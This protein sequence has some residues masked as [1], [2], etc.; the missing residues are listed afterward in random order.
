M[1]VPAYLYTVPVNE[2]EV[3]VE[4]PPLVAPIDSE[5]IVPLHRVVAAKR[6]IAD[7][8]LLR[9][10]ARKMQPG[11]EAHKA[12]LGGEAANQLG[13]KHLGER[14]V[15]F[16]RGGVEAELG[17]SHEQLAVAYQVHLTGVLLVGHQK[18]LA[19][20]LKQADELERI[21]LGELCR[22]V[23]KRRTGAQ[24]AGPEAGLHRPVEAGRHTPDSVDDRTVG[25]TCPALEG[26]EQRLETIEYR[27]EF[28]QF[29]LAQGGE[30]EFLGPAF[31]A[32]QQLFGAYQKRL[33]SG[34]IHYVAQ[35]PHGIG[36]VTVQNLAKHSL[37]LAVAN[38]V[39]INLP[40]TFP[41][42]LL[43]G[44]A[45]EP[46]SLAFECDTRIKHIPAAG[47]KGLLGNYI[48][49]G[50]FIKI[51]RLR[52]SRRDIRNAGTPGSVGGSIVQDLIHQQGNPVFGNYI[53]PGFVKSGI[54]IYCFRLEKLL[55]VLAQH[56]GVENETTFESL[57]LQCE[58]ILHQ[59]RC[60]QSGTEEFD[61]FGM[62]TK[63]RTAESSESED[64]KIKIG[65]FYAVLLQI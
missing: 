60:G 4:G 39:D 16:Q 43:D 19:D 17:R 25:R 34:H 3:E 28:L 15:V 2:T 58:S 10:R 64:S 27:S 8:I 30:V 47:E 14:R 65:T 40:D 48:D 1:L 9:S 35:E 45:Q 44:V 61:K 36:R 41:E 23:F 33:E 53:F 50:I 32:G 22:H 59:R 6:Q 13:F 37:S 42:A 46:Y 11:G 54:G 31:Y 21:G 18:A 5:E 12:G 7:E 29:L 55:D 57:L 38:G 63:K 20:A 62:H 56:L 49:V 26:Q 51:R 52:L 24:Q